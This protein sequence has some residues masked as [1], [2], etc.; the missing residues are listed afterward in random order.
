MS[1]LSGAQRRKR[2]RNR[3][4]TQAQQYRLG[5][6]VQQAWR[7]SGLLITDEQARRYAR[8]VLSSS[9]IPVRN[10]PMGMVE[11]W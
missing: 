8:V 2:A 11:L 7:D 1:R 3:R 9:G 10:E 5:R 4:Q 6:F